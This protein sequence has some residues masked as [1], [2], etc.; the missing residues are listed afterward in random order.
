MVEKKLSKDELDRGERMFY[1]LAFT[2]VIYIFI[3]QRIKDFV[4]AF[5]IF[6]SKSFNIGSAAGP[7]VADLIAFGL[8]GIIIHY[9]YAYYIHN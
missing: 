2:S 4:S 9:L 8:I 3:G 7:L 5:Q 1:E 6:L